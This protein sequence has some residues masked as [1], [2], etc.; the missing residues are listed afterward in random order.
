MY[1][2]IVHPP[3]PS[4]RSSP[5]EDPAMAQLTSSEKDYVRKLKRK[6]RLDILRTIDDDTKRAK[7]SDAPL[8]I[9]LLQHETMP[10]SLRAHIFDELRSSCSDKMTQWAGKVLRLPFGRRHDNPDV[11]ITAASAVERARAL[12]DKHV[13]GHEKAK[14]E[15]MKMVCQTKCGATA[16]GAYALGL[17]GL[18]G[19]GKTHFVRHALAPALGRPMVSIPL[20]GATDIAYLMGNVYTYE[21]SKEGRLASALMEAGCCDPI[22]YF[23]EVD[24][25]SGSD[26]GQEI[27]SC[28]IHLIDPTANSALRDRYLH[29][30]DLDFSKCTFVFSYNDP[31]AVSPILLDRIKR[32]G[33]DPPTPDQ[34][35]AIVCEHLVPRVQERLNTT[36]RLDEAAV[37]CVLRKNKMDGMRG[38]EKDVDHVIA[39]AQ[40]CCAGTT[41]DGT[42]VGA[43]DV[44][45]LTPDGRV[46]VEFAEAVL[47]EDLQEDAHREPPRG[48][49]M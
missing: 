28:L 37:D 22:I 11:E 3:Y 5:R 47:H 49:Y 13:T 17:E 9:R 24:K 25:V 27:I 1:A 45:V 10:P 48:M 4:R 32:V 16:G 41:N 21:G 23:D 31:Y 8:R 46:S 44:C 35:R 26:R 2:A 39:S 34:R 19:T 38:A 18:P 15:V 40:L 6:S 36:L 20:G 14:R 33:I 30:V 7:R 43:E 42:L 12:M 29:N